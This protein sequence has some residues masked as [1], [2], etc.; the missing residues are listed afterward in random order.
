[1]IVAEMLKEDIKDY[2]HTEP[3]TTMLWTPTKAS[4]TPTNT[5]RCYQINGIDWLY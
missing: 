1:M 5:E 3:I 2:D 4:T